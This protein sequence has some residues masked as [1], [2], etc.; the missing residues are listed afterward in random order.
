MF[1]VANAYGYCVLCVLFNHATEHAD[2]HTRTWHTCRPTRFA[3]PGNN[4]LRELWQRVSSEADARHAMRLQVEASRR[5]AAVEQHIDFSGA[6]AMAAVKVCCARVGSLLDLLGR[7]GDMEGGMWWHAP[8]QPC[9]YCMAPKPL[10]SPL[11]CANAQL[12]RS[13][14]RQA[15]ALRM[16][17]PSCCCGARSLGCR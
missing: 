2:L 7:G 6:V 1:G 16:P 3:G 15:Q 14:A 5:R 17:Q 9:P 8:Y 11:L 12:W 4:A 13:R 10:P